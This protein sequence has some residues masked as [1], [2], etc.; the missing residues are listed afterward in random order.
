LIKGYANSFATKERLEEKQIQIRETPWF[1]TS[2]I[3]IGTHLGEMN[4]ADSSLYQESITYGL[5]NGINFIDTALNYRGMKSERDVG[6][7]LNN[8]I[9]NQQEIKR[10]EVVVSTKAGIIPGDID[11]KLV[12]T[13]Y[14]EEILIGGGVLTEADVNIVDHHRHTMTPSYFKFAIGESRK[15]LQLET[16]DIYYLHNPEISMMVLGPDAFYSRLAELFAF[17]EKMV[18]SGAIR[19]YGIAT[20]SGLLVDPEESGYLSLERVVEVARK[21]AGEDHHCRFTQFPFNH[22]QQAGKM[23]LNQQVN[24]KWLSVLDAARELGLQ[25]TTSAPFNL[26]KALETEDDARVQLMDVLGTDGI[27]AAMVGMRRVQNVER[28]L[29]VIRELTSM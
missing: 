27:L 20:W 24:G 28:N 10:E 22:T 18:A 4:D 14:L 1:Y 13:K 9:A 8:L 5:R 15:H 26:G 3:A 2:P 25:A 17:F 23:K 21:V 11:K 16:I 29:Q 19:L 12:P 6:K 7:V